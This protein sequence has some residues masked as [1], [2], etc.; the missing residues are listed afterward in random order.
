[1]KIVLL[2]AALLQAQEGPN[3]GTPPD[4]RFRGPPPAAAASH[5]GS[6]REL[7]V[8]NPWAASADIRVDGRLDDADWTDA[9]VLHGFTQYEPVEGI[10]A[11]QPT[12][13]RVLVTEEAIYFGVEALDEPGGIRAT[14]ARRDGFRR[15]D[16]YVRI[17]LDTY[18]D[19]RRAF[20]FQVNPLGVQADGLWAEGQRGRGDPI[21]WS[22]DFL[23]ESAGRVGTDRWVAEVRVPLASLRFPD[24]P[25]QSWGLQIQR[26]LQRNG[27]ASSWAPLSR[28]SANRLAQSGTLSGLRDLDPGRFMEVNPVVTGRQVGA[29]DEARGTLRHEPVSGAF[30]LGVT[31]GLTSNLTLDG[32]YN[33]DFSQVEA[34]AG[35][36]TVN[37]RFALRLPEKRPFFLEGTDVF[38]M[39]AQL[40]YTRSIANPL[41]AAK[42]SGKVGGFSVAWLGAVDRV[43]GDP[44]GPRVNLLRVRRDVGRSSTVGM[45]YTDRTQPGSSYNRVL[46]AD[47]RLVLGGR[48]TLDVLAAG[49]ADGMAG[50]APDW[51]SLV[52]A[53]FNRSGRNLSLEGSFEDVGA[54]F[55]ARSGFIRR[56]GVTELEGG[57][58]Y[59]WRGGEGALVESWGPRVEL[60]GTWNR[61]DFWAGRG[62]EE[63]ELQLSLSASFRGNVGGFVSFSRSMF[64]VGAE[65]YTGLFVADGSGAA[66]AP[67][68]PS[69]DLFSGLPSVRLR[70]WIGTWERVR[71]SL[72]GSWSETPV[73]ERWGGLPADVAHALGGDVDVSLQP[74]GSL[75]A[76]VG[77]RHTTLR[78]TRDGSTY[79]S[80]TIPRVQA[81]YQLSRSLFARAT[82]EYAAQERGAVLDPSTGRPLLVCDAGACS[83]ATGSTGYDFSIEGL[84]GYEPSPGTV[85]FLGYARQMRDELRFR[86]RDVTTR[87]DGLFVKLSYRFRM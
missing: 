68:A 66:G 17:V 1:L 31:Y 86:F 9:P 65:E 81:R 24:L 79:S 46:G 70:S 25:V 8:V 13:V 44:A 32:T 19:Q 16:D 55:R 43:D 80:A 26:T 53:R 56:T 78:R 45:V 4:G 75:S 20:V 7:D 48:Y 85:V 14:L 72:G 28:G 82:G 11:S 41:G 30:G 2:L 38:N 77:L 34:D 21:D 73:F 10:P 62:P 54:T 74:T 63:A 18:H 64:A 23:W 35:Q 51:G 40:V 67:F 52:L 84:V 69:R 58:G 3:E 36:I 37:E 5:D 71:L 50:A 22:P 27:H 39:P 15:T 29:W 60:Q 87:E 42:L 49:S 57:A 47:G 76:S 33:P 83:E 12:R 6:A 61:D 59:T